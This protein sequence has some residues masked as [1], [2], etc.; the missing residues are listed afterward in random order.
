M[1]TSLSFCARW[2]V[3]FLALLTSCAFPG[4]ETVPRRV[5]FD[6]SAFSAYGKPG[7][8][9]VTGRLIVTSGDGVVHAGS[10]NQ[11]MMG[12]TPVTLLPV[13]AYTREMVDREIGNGERL[14]LSDPRFKKYVRAT[15]TDANGNFA[16]HQIPAGQ[17]FVSGMAEWLEMG[18]F[19]YQWACEGIS[20]GRG[21]ASV[22]GSPTI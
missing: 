20:V 10:A 8:G 3:V 2:P 12:D 13:T 17:Y 16:F 5:A 11:N 22:S 6:E 18:E 9:I 19:K 14:P 7:A 4:S 15:K 1:K 21:Q